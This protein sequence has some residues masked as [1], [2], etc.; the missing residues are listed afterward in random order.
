MD[1]SSALQELY[2]ERQKVERAIAALQ[3]L[4]ATYVSHP[5]LS[6][7]NRRGRKSMNAKERIE[8]SQRMKKYWA[9]R[10]KAERG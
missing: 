7:G 1:I 6:S 10:R 8:V 4:Q 5:D 3:E 2:A 9:N